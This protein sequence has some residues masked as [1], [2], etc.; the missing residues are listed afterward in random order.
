MKTAIL[1]KA[2]ALEALACERGEGRKCER[3]ALEIYS[4]TYRHAVTILKH[5]QTNIKFIRT[6]IY[7]WTEMRF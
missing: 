2:N 7:L 3:H 4:H 1:S 5:T 6:K